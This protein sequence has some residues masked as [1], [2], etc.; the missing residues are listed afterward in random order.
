MPLL[1]ESAPPWLEREGPTTGS[2]ETQEGSRLAWDHQRG[3]LTV[4]RPELTYTRAFSLEDEPIT[5][6]LS[7]SQSGDP[8][9]NFIKRLLRLD[10][11]RHR[12]HAELRGQ[13][14]RI[15]LQATVQDAHAQTLLE[16]LPW[17][18]GRGEAVSELNDVM[19][20]ASAWAHQS[21]S[22]CG[23]AS[24]L[25]EDARAPRER[26]ASEILP[27]DTFIEPR[28]ALSSWGVFKDDWTTSRFF[29]LI[30]PLFFGLPMLLGGA[31]LHSVETRYEEEA[32]TVEAQV[33][34]KSSETSDG[35]TTYYVEYRFSPEGGRSVD[36]EDSLPKERW[37]PLEDGDLLEI[38]Y[39]PSEPSRNRIAGQDLFA[40]AWGLM[41]VSCIPLGIAAFFWTRSLTRAFRAARLYQ[42]GTPVTGL[43]TGVHNTTY[44]VN[45]RHWHYITYTYPDHQGRSHEGQ[46]HGVSPGSLRFVEGGGIV[47]FY[48]PKRP[49]RHAWERPITV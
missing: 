36:G 30:F 25:P 34:D 12:L 43:V 4:N 13:R 29:S 7:R 46:T 3:T 31:Y 40:L 39:I 6:H 38:D 35:S 1:P 23:L 18:E 8:N 48:D 44:Q 9:P 2:L 21:P 37:T 24:W 14:E 20:L 19:D 45:D 17:K 27:N 32:V 42:H 15:L 49:E 33:V 22:S 5:V 47:I 28:P 16:G 11:P 41:L 10:R 26:G